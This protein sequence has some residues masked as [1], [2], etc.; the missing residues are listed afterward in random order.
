MVASVNTLKG[1]ASGRMLGVP[2]ARRRTT[3]FHCP[4]WEIGWTLLEERPDCELLPE[5]LVQELIRSKGRWKKVVAFLENVMEDQGKRRTG[6]G[7]VTT[8]VTRDSRRR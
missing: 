2:T 8:A 1:K 4:R 7:N 3:V 5:T 6:D